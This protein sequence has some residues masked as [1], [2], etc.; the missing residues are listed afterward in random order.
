MRNFLN[1]AFLISS[2]YTPHITCKFHH[3]HHRP[4][5][6]LLGIYEDVITIVSSTICIIVVHSVYLGVNWSR[7]VAIC[8]N[9]RKLSSRAANC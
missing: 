3:L 9:V 6:R 4:E 2:L 5:Q 7:V 8:L 1:T